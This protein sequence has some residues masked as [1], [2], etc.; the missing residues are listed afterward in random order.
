ML[1]VHRRNPPLNSTLIATG[2]AIAAP[3]GSCV[4]VLVASGPKRRCVHDIMISVL[5]RPL[6]PPY[7]HPIHPH[8]GREAELYS[9]QANQSHARD[10]EDGSIPIL[11]RRKAI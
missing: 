3:L 6:R 10:Q 11:P 4:R 7:I 5:P 1:S 8:C 9:G 2:T